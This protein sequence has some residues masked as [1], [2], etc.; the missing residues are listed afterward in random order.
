MLFRSY[1]IDD[2]GKIQ[3]RG[4][5]TKTDYINDKNF[6]LEWCGEIKADSVIAFTDQKKITTLIDE[7]KINLFDLKQVICW[8]KGDSGINPRGNFVNAF[9]LGIY[10]RKKGSKWY[11]NGSTINIFRFNRGRSPFHPTQK[12]LQVI[13]Y[14][15]RKSVV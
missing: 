5:I 4:G 14:L 2:L 15:D 6:P 8:D 7:L 12:P 3:M 11:G 13:S 1:N 9:E 10:C